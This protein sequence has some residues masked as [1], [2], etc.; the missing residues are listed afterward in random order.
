MEILD[1]YILTNKI[2]Y[3]G[4]HDNI[5]PENSIGAI[6]K[7]IEKGY[8]LEL[9]LRMLTDGTIVVFHDE[10]LGRMTKTDGFLSNCTYD[11]IKGLTLL[12]SKEH[13]PTLEEV[14]KVIDSKVPV[15]FDIRNI[16]MIGIEKNIWKILKHYKGEYARTTSFN[17]VNHWVN[18]FLFTL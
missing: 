17:N 10:R 4:L 6:K 3:R 13:I 7:T 8:A 2:I 5:T 16:D 12:K 18:H 14:L 1:S 15:I 9:D 11:D